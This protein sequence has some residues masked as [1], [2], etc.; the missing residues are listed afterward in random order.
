MLRPFVCRK[1]RRISLRM[2][3]NAQAHL[4][5][6]TEFLQIDFGPTLKADLDRG[7]IRMMAGGTVAHS[8]VQM[9]LY[10]YLGGIL[11]G[12]GCRPY[13]SDMA[14]QATDWSVRYPDLA[15]DC[16]STSERPHDK[17]LSS[18]CVV[19]GVLSASTRDHDLSVKLGEYRAIGSIHTVAFVDP[20]EQT[21]AVT[22]RTERGG[23]T[24]LVFA[25][26][27]GLEIPAMDLMVPR[28]EVFA[29]D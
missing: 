12:S 28:D 22:R 8:V 3:T 1:R 2:A 5:T 9:N 29:T 18:P 4:V 19:V 6:A 25:A 16:G 10:R 26:D 27:C 11:R 17:V 21:I 20:D 23:W 7:F 13:G 14:V 24:D 15:I